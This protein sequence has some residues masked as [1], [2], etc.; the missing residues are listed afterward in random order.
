[1]ISSEGIKVNALL[2]SSDQSLVLWLVC[3]WEQ[4]YTQLFHW[5]N[6]VFLKGFRDKMKGV[7]R[8]N[9]AFLL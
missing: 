1:M 4:M 9:K 7:S 5:Y 3:K 2:R 8:L 6:N